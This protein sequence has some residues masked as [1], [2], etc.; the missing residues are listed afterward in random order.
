MNNLSSRLQHVFVVRLWSEI[1]DP[2]QAQWRGSV[3]HIPTGERM[4]FTSLVDM[5]DFIRF[6]LHTLPL[7]AEPEWP[8][9]DTTDQ[10][11][12]DIDTA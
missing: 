9:S 10:E 3:E 7:P 11:V 6:H 1:S 4:Y 5:T 2:N 8:D 12:P